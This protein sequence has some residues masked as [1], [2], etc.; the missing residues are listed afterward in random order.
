MFI[1]DPACT[2]TAEELNLT[3][4]QVVEAVKIAAV[5][6]SHVKR[7]RDQ[8]KRVREEALREQEIA[9]EEEQHPDLCFCHRRGIEVVHNSD[10]DPIIGET[11]VYPV[12]PYSNQYT[13]VPVYRCSHCGKG[14]YYC[15]AWA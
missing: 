12:S 14:W 10:V 7:L 9:R 5:Y 1:S 13:K 2:R 11:K 8:R 4:Q 3:R 6:E 15:A